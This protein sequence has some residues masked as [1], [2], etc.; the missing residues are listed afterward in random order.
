MT[1]L[2]A[3]CLKYGI[4]GLVLAMFIVWAVFVY[5]GGRK[6][7]QA[8]EDLLR[9]QLKQQRTDSE[10]ERQRDRADF[11]AEQ[12]RDREKIIELENELE[13]KERRINK[14]IQN[15]QPTPHPFG[16]PKQTEQSPADESD[17]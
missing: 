10:L 15:G 3:E 13:K 9:E 4:P 8:I 6:S 2:I 1:E 5:P 11:E 16:K 14:L 17:K 7:C 12:Q